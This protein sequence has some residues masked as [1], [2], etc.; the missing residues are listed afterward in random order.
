M[1]LR[2]IIT[3]GSLAVALVCVFLLTRT[4]SAEEKAV[5]ETKRALRQQGFKTELSEFNFSFPPKCALALPRYKRVPGLGARPRRVQS[6][7]CALAR[8]PRPYG[9]GGLRRRPGGLETGSVDNSWRS[10]GIPTGFTPSNS[11]LR[12]ETTSEPSPAVPPTA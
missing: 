9:S 5:E 12:L 3:V 11:S 6:A 7:F 8:Q 1:K 4:D 10:R 2:W